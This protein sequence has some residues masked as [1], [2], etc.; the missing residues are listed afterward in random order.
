MKDYEHVD[1][2]VTR[3]VGLAILG[4]LATGCSVHDSG[5]DP[6]RLARQATTTSSVLA[7][8][9]DE[10]AG[11][12]AHDASGNAN[13][14]SVRGAVWTAQ[15]KFGG[16]L[17]FAG[18]S[19]VTVPKGP[20][21]DNVVPFTYCAW[22]KPLDMGGQNDGR[23]FH[24]GT[25]SARKQLNL[26]SSTTNGF[27]LYVDRSGQR[28][29]ALSTHDAVAMGI[30]NYVCGTYSEIDG[31]RLYVNAIE[32]SYALRDVGSGATTSD[33]ADNLY[34]GNRPTKDKGF[35]GAIDEVRMYGR[36]L[37]VLEM[38]MDMNSSVNSAADGGVDATAPIESGASDS[39]GAAET[40]GDA[41]SEGGTDAA[42]DS[43]FDATADASADSGFDATAE[44]SAD[45][46]FDATAD[47]GAP[48][49][50]KD[51]GTAAYPLKV[52]PT[53]RYLVDQNGAPFLIAGDS[54]QALIVNLSA[55]NADSYFADRAAH[56][57]N[58]VLVDIVANRYTAGRD[59][60]S[61]YDG[62]VPFTTP[63]DLSTPNESYFQRADAAI[64]AAARRGLV[65]FLDPMETGGWLGIMGANGVAK[66]RAYGQY[67]GRRY[68]SFDNIVWQS[69]NDF[70]TWRTPGDDQVVAAVALGIKDTDTRHIHTVELDYPISAS[71]DDPTWQSISS[72]SADYAYN[73]TYAETLKDYNRGLMPVFFTEGVYEYESQFQTHVATPLTLRRQEYWSILS[74]AAGQFYGNHYTWQFASNWQSF[75]D[76]PGAVQM[77]FVA[78]LFTTRP[79]WGLVPDQAHLLVTAGIGTCDGSGDV[80]SSD[81]LTAGR[82]ADGT[83]AMAYMPTARTITVD[84]TRMTRPGIAKWYDPTSGA[85]LVVGSYQ[86]AGSGQF[87]TPGNNAG[88]DRDWVFVLE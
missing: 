10:G 81:C 46:G 1:M 61:T 34:V 44:A 27:G 49:A 55:A 47:S 80:D 83:L 29:K 60:A 18:S 38:Q 52:G 71:T 68:A 41:A 86:N 25:N 3:G 13:H 9:L 5:D 50:G 8:G 14:G 64:R 19:V 32:V 22:I 33:A 63:G 24:K 65:V 79:W 53:N 48:D 42:A 56:G 77:P 45:S 7:F 75:L 16:A 20:R 6:F 59:D 17:S 74:G 35:H 87:V 54:P 23:I 2:K 57:F 88:G 37:S 85:Y 12:V 26:D 39:S 70:Q 67:L 4:A 78:A 31:P 28:A 58:A 36:A 15:G 82:S 69:G 21:V 11:T 73:P 40:G 51:G 43:G 66:D 72:I 76:S 30:W 62:I 84:L